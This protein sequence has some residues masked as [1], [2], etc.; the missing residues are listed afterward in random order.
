MNLW[1]IWFRHSCRRRS[2]ERLLILSIGLLIAGCFSATDASWLQQEGVD[3][4]HYDVDLTVDAARLR[5]EGVASL[6][7]VRETEVQEVN[8]GLNGPRIDSAFVDGVRVS[9][10]SRSGRHFTIPLDTDRDT[11]QV[12]IH[13]QGSPRDG[14]YAGQ[15]A[16][17][18]IVY[19]DGWPDR[20]GGWL[21]GVHNPADPA[22]FD[23]T[24]RYDSSLTAVG[25]G[26]LVYTEAGVSQWTLSSPTPVYTFAF[27]LG[28]FTIPLDTD[29]D[30][31][32]VTIHYQ[33]SPRDGLYAGQHA[34]YRIVY[35]DGWPDRAGGW[36]PG[37]HN[38]ADPATFDLTLR[39][40]SS[41]T[42]VGSGRLVY[43][44]AGVSQWTLSSPTPVYTFAFALA[45]FEHVR[46]ESGALPV[47]HFAVP[48]DI[49]KA[50]YGLRRTHDVIAFF[51]RLLGP[52]PY[53][54]FTTVQVPF[55]FAG[56]ENAATPFFSTSLYGSDMLEEVLV[57][58]VAHQWIGNDLTIADWTELW[59][60]EGITTYLTT[61]FYEFADGAD[62][63]NEMRA[64]FSS[65]DS[66]IGRPL[67]PDR[68]DSPDEMLTW[69]VYRK[70]ASVMHLLRLKLGDDVFFETLRQWYLDHRGRPATTTSLKDYFE[71]GSDESLDGFFDFWVYN[72][73]LPRLVTR[74]DPD[75]GMISWHINGD[76]GLLEDVPFQI[77]LSTADGT[78]FVEAGEGAVAVESTEAPAVRPVGV[79]M[80]VETE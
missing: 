80:I 51:E 71:A 14:L 41:L 6:T 53:D 43:T 33:G 18:R 62:R 3:V 23:L 68:I 20:A 44:E 60:S 16:G 37:V 32:Q 67:V 64:D 13:Y 61:L 8:L 31:L 65:I 15:H 35:T 22:T 55:E 4:I 5:I 7:L 56:M 42:A 9:H 73:A 58:E 24:L 54:H 74:W 70:G 12:T 75:S 59:L 34:G 30:T 17:Y 40:D 2:L 21:P 52:Y 57:H 28:H 25:S 48:P 38:P 45:P 66:G 1:M 72:A 39:Y 78:W 47:V 49:R 63:A 27:A 77:E 76:Q 29:R 50:T 19:T 26:R 79:T 10:I 11:L 36:L 46:D 69:L